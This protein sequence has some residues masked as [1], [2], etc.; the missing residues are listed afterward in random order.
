MK[1]IIVNI[2]VAVLISLVFLCANVRHR[3]NT[4]YLEGVAGEKAGDFMK[5]LT[6]YESAIRM[7][8]PFSSKVEN[9]AE[10]I[11]ALAEAAEKR[12]NIEQALV[13]YRSLRSAFYAV[14]W[15][16]QPGELW[17]RRC[18]AKIA[19]LAQMRKKAAP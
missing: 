2:T 3:Q 9:S 15:L 6:G 11:W 17:I 19:V 4:Q 13:A 18:D 1:K 10:R 7:Y 16:R 14:Q 8:L 5:A 12:Q